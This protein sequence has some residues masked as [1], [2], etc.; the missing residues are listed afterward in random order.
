MLLCLFFSLIFIALAKPRW[1]YKDIELM[2]EDANLVILL[3]SS[4]SM[5]VSDVIQ[6]DMKELNKRSQILLINFIIIVLA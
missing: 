1:D 5:D 3:D 2:Q 4:K 6:P